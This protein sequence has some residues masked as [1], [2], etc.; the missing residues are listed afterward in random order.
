MVN[1]MPDGTAAKVNVHDFSPTH[2]DIGAMERYDVVVAAEAA[3]AQSEIAHTTRTF[4]RRIFV[5]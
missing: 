2:G 3:A 5:P 4:K 1:V